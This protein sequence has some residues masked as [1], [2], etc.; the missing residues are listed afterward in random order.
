MAK[1]EKT[2][3]NSKGEE[4]KILEATAPVAPQAPVGETKEKGKKNQAIE[5]VY[6]KADGTETNQLHEVVAL[7]ISTKAGTDTLK[8]A[9]LPNSMRIA[10]LVFGLNTT[11]RNA[12][13]SVAHAG[14]DGPQALKNRLVGIKNGE[15][16][17][18]GEGGDDGIPQVIHAMIRAKKDGNAYTDGMEEVWLG[19]YRSLTKEGKAE[20]TKTMSAKKPI[21][22]ALLKIKAEAAAAKAQAAISAAGEQGGEDF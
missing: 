18:A 13:N 17:T 11:L 7:R 10:G 12:H 15:W 4:G 14:G 2:A 5:V 20:W 6:L 1:Q 22:L 19:Q 16:R 21:A 8:L 9:D 3:V